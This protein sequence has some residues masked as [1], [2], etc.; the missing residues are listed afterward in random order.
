[1]KHARHPLYVFSI[2]TGSAFLLSSIILAVFFR[3][4]H[5]YT[6]FAFGFWLVLDWIDYKL[7]GWSLLGYFANKKHRDI[8][9][10]FF[11]L[12]TISCFIIDYLF[13]VRLYKL[14]EWPAYDQVH[15]IRMY[16][17]MNVTFIMGMYELYRVI[18]WTVR[19]VFHKKQLWAIHL[20]HPLDIFL[21]KAA[22]VTGVTLLALPVYPL[23]TGNDTHIEYALGFSF[24]GM[25][26]IA[27]SLTFFLG[28]K[29]MFGAIARM[30][31]VFFLSILLT[32]ILGAGT[33]EVLNLFAGE[34]IYTRMPFDTITIMSIPVFVFL[35]W[36]PLIFSSISLI[37]LIRRLDY[38]KDH[39]LLH[40]EN[41]KQL[42]VSS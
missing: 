4:P 7:T 34:W 38:V 22:L 41:L 3:S 10:V 24:F 42:R 12:A 5:F 28:G 39:H 40:L 15:F 20:A 13:G 16:L 31:N 11:I 29:T 14:W 8:F 33:T 35:G 2:L 37:K 9:V 32:I 23:I 17:V 18:R 36:I 6:M 26:L 27:D 21:W 1:M 25:F 30:D 19:H